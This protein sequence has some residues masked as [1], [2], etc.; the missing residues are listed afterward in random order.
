[1]KMELEMHQRWLGN[2][3]P[4]R[5]RAVEDKTPSFHYPVWRG[6]HFTPALPPTLGTQ[7]EQEDMAPLSPS[8]S[9]M[10]YARWE[11]TLWYGESG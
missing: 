9:F 10:P 5:Q 11:F 8:R 7:E 6:A 1:M 3:A 4:G 2:V